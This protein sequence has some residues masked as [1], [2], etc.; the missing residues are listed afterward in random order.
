MTTFSSYKG[1]YFQSEKAIS[2]LIEAHVGLVKKVVTTMD[3]YLPTGY[4]KDDFFSIGCW[5]L[6][7]AAHKFDPRKGVAFKSFAYLRIRGAVIDELRK[8]T[9]GGQIM[10]KKQ[11]QITH[12]IRAAQ[13]KKQNIVTDKEVAVEL[14]VSETV[15]LDMLAQTNV[16][17]VLAADEQMSEIEGGV[18]PEAG[19]EEEEQHM[20]LTKAIELLPEKEKLVLSLY[21]EK[22][23]S[24]KEIGA[25][26]GLTESRVS[27]IHKKAVLTIR[28]HVDSWTK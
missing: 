3:I 1:E 23:L 7:E 28:A 11:Q 14:G 27:Q 13:E 10:V 16:M 26:M 24:L 8:Q 4:E 21:Y 17:H 6:I 19:I 12:A 20:L 25:V 18:R 15:Y 5:G 9:F 2:D 22:E